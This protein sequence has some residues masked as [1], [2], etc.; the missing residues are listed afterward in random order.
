M[1]NILSTINNSCILG[2]FD[3]IMDWINGL[4]GL[5]FWSLCDIFFILAD[6]ME[7]LFRMFAGIYEGGVDVNGEKVEG[8]IV[9]Y[10][11]QSEIVQQ[12]FMSILILSF[13][14]LIMFTIF[15]IVKN[16]Y[17]EK[18]EPV[19][20]IIGSSMKALL[21]YLMVPI[22]TIVCLLV[23]NIVLQAID[24]ATRATANGGTA[25]DMLFMSAA[26]NAN[27]M[28]HEDIE[29]REKELNR[30]IKNGNLNNKEVSDM[31]KT[32][33][34]DTSNPN[35]AYAV[36]DEDWDNIAQIIDDAFISNKLE[37][38]SDKWLA[39][40]VMRYYSLGNISLITVWAGGAFL[41]IAIGKMT[42]GLVSRIFKMTLY[43]A[44][45]PAVMAM[46]P[47]KGDGALKSWTG[48]MVKQGTM[49]Y[50][51]I[52]VLNIIYS[53]LPAFNDIDIGG[54]DGLGARI[55]K[56]LIMIIAFTGAKDLIGTISGWF[57]TGNALSEG[58]STKKAVMDPLKKYGQ[59]AAGVFGGFVGGMKEAKDHGAKTGFW[60]GV[61]GAS[62][63]AMP[64]L[65]KNELAESYQKE[66]KA[67]KE[68]Y[69]ELKT[70]NLLGENKAD[71]SADLYAGRETLNKEN[72]ALTRLLADYDDAVTRNDKDDQKRIAK[73]IASTSSWVKKVTEKDLATLEN[74]EKAN[75]ADRT[76]VGIFEEYEK[77]ADNIK[78]LAGQVMGPSWTM[79][80]TDMQKLMAGD[81]R[82]L[83]AD[84]LKNWKIYG[85]DLLSSANDLKHQEA[86]IDNLKANNKKFRDF[87]TSH[88]LDDYSSTNLGNTTVWGDFVKE[89]GK[90]ETLVERT[91]S[92]L[93]AARDYIEFDAAGKTITAARQAVNDINSISEKDL[94][95]IG[96][97]SKS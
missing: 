77:A 97:E 13:F 11:I 12:I 5:L 62:N 84:Q 76:N 52:G 82:G 80:S 95:D 59:K 75:E 51:S 65:F 53:I 79:N 63:A 69:T 91:K 94:K 89:L 26:Y 8:D 28:R 55:V 61:M 86:N 41:I 22:A 58:E 40:C 23:G 30:M 64:G 34:V 66:K 3:G 14:L 93:K 35:S 60:G 50:C 72:K 10:L 17:A 92:S 57:G 39:T 44:I 20:K 78:N 43:Y 21:M 71:G 85:G 54:L 1:F 68:K 74:K 36:A 4:I 48:E 33:G 32:Y 49:A 16:Q 38:L 25:S 96:K 27:W 47:I 88:K 24:G 45:S 46:F 29:R 56:L 42:W 19:S 6:L 81:T 9:L 7:M 83:T 15:A 87:I 31:L 67:A 18:Q 37:G 90:T 70:K 2:A 73:K